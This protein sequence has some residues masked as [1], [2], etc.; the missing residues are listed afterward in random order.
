MAG[1][2]KRAEGVA[3]CARPPA[4]PP[5][6]LATGVH[7]ASH[8]NRSVG[9]LRGIL[10]AQLEAANQTYLWLISIFPDRAAISSFHYLHNKRAS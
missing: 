3:Y 4:R 10:Q 8:G 1:L 6:C 7:V 5:G 2:S 9:R